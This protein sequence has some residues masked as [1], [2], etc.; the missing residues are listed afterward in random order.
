MF[1][2]GHKLHILVSRFEATELQQHLRAGMSNLLNARHARQRQHQRPDT[3]I[4]P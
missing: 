4:C 1:N 3:L 2:V